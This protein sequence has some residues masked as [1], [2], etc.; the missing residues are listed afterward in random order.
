MP[1]YD[2]TRWSQ[3][4]RDQQAAQQQ[5]A[6]YIPPSAYEP[7]PSKPR[8]PRRQPPKPVPNPHA[9]HV[10]RLC[11]E[12]R[13]Y[14]LE[15]WIADRKSTAMPADYKKRSPLRIRFA[16]D[17]SMGEQLRQR[18]AT[19]GEKERAELA[20]FEKVLGEAIGDAFI[21]DL[22]KE[23]A[24]NAWMSAP[25]SRVW[26]RHASRMRR[27]TAAEKLRLTPA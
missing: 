18:A 21:A 6:P 10:L 1:R 5:P 14:E 11:Q 26:R 8:A 12:G 19:G 13:L 3:R 16:P 4:V 20:A 27:R 15:Q 2:P 24:A 23:A 9:D 22:E 17:L 7:R 25:G